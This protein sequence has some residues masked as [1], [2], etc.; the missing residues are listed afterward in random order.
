[1][2]SLGWQTSLVKYTSRKSRKRT[3]V[4]LTKAAP[5]ALARRPLPMIVAPRSLGPS[6]GVTASAMRAGSLSIAP[7]AQPSVSSTSRFTAVTVLAGSLSKLISA[8]N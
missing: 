4:P 1:M 6:E 2:F 3:C 8:A 7:S 5:D